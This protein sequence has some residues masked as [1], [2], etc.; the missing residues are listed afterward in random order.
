MRLDGDDLWLAYLIG[1]DDSG[2]AVLRFEQVDH[3]SFGPPND[4]RL[5]LHPLW[6]QGLSFYEF[7]RIND[8]P[9]SKVHWVATFHDG[10]L[11]VIATTCRVVAIKLQAVD[12]DA[13]LVSAGGRV[14]A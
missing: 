4:E 12:E 5:H 14:K 11:D 8:A 2:Y 13:A 6:S 10:T 3:Y 1:G 9:P 7:H